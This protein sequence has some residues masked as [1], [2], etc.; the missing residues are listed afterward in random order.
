[1]LDRGRPKYSLK[2]YVTLAKQLERI[3][4]HFLAIKDMAGPAQGRL[5]ADRLK[6]AYLGM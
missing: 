6:R 3:G 1:M 2:Y 5:A 4:V